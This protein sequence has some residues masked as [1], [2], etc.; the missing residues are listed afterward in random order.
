MKRLAV[1][2]PGVGYTPDKPL[3]YHSR[4]IA[5]ALGFDIL[6]LTFS[7]FPKK[8]KGDEKKMRKSFDLAL[9]QSREQ[10]KEADLIFMDVELSDG[11]CFEIFKRTEAGKDEQNARI[12]HDRLPGSALGDGA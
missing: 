4:R 10:L 1:F 11:N 12:Q 6:T 5:E 9:M 8:I 2:F 3:L 7:G